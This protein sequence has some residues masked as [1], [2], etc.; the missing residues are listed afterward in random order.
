MVD[1]GTGAGFPGIPLKVTNKNIQLTL[2][3]SQRNKAL[4]LGVLLSRIGLP[5]VNIFNNRG[6]ELARDG[7]FRE[8][9]DVVTMRE[10]G[11]IPLNLE[12]GLP[13]V[14]MGGYLVLWKGKEDLQKLEKYKEFATELGGTFE[15]PFKYKLNDNKT[16]YLFILKKGW[17]TPKK[18]PRSYA[19]II[20]SARKDGD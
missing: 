16:R 19:S 4:F 15:E 5:E 18:Y 12:I 13:F 1:V 14:K 20:K 8:Q 11:R 9:F 7:A 10:F 3:E 6:E 2:I 17:N